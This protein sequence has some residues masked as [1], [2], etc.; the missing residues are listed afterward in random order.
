MR[1]L[2]T[3]NCRVNFKQIMAF[4]IEHWL[5]LRPET[6]C[7]GGRWIF[8]SD[9]YMNV[10]THGAMVTKV[11]FKYAA[12]RSW[13]K[14][15]FLDVLREWRFKK[16]KDLL[17]FDRLLVRTDQIFVWGSINKIYP[18]LLLT[19]GQNWGNYLAALPR[20]DP[21]SFAS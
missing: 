15:R 17:T 8:D 19:Y 14:Q 5:S 6:E 12:Y 3:R 13:P 7:V 2:K 1:A 11:K 4:G 10:S 21:V 9:V 16:N 18:R 20:Q